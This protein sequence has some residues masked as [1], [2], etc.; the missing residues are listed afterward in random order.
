MTSSTVRHLVIAMH[1][2]VPK[3]VKIQLPNHKHAPHKPA[4]NAP[5]IYKTNRL[6]I[7]NPKPRAHAEC[8]AKKSKVDSLYNVHSKYVRTQLC[9]GMWHVIALKCERTVNALFLLFAIFVG[10][11]FVR[12]NSIW[13]NKIAQRQRHKVEG[14]ERERGER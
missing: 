11:P 2:L 12:L 5:Y 13:G 8:S 10:R 9:C 1:Y 7:H 3:H 6:R 14:K 4:N